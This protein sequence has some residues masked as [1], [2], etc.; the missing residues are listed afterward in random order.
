[1]FGAVQV[2]ELIMDNHNG[3]AEGDT[4]VTVSSVASGFAQVEVFQHNRLVFSLP[5]AARNF[6]F[7]DVPLHTPLFQMQKSL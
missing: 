4:T 7:A 2:R 1:M 6:S 3:L 5:T